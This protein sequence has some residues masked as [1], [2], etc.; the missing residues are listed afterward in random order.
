M[1]ILDFMHVNTLIY[2]QFQMYSL[3]VGFFWG[4]SFSKLLHVIETA[5]YNSYLSLWG[6]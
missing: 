6:N 2:S 3:R 1:V 4:K 5:K